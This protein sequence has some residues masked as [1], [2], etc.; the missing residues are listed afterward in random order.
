MAYLQRVLRE[1]VGLW[2]SPLVRVILAACLAWGRNGGN[3]DFECN[4]FRSS[5]KRR[6]RIDLNIYKNLSRNS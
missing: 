2:P 6:G 5:S 4:K 1:K 3:Q